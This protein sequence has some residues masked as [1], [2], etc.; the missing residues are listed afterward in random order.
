MIDASMFIKTV[1]ERQWL[2]I[3]CI[4]EIAYR[5]GYI[6]RDTLRNIAQSFKTSYGDYLNAIAEENE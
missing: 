1:E 2:K 6:S 4:E 3:G 5:M